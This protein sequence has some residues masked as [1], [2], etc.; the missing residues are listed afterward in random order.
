MQCDNTRMMNNRHT[1][2][3]ST[4][5]LWGQ[6]WTGRHPRATPAME[7]PSIGKTS[8]S[9]DQGCPG[10]SIEEPECPSTN[11]TEMET[12][13]Q[14]RH[15][16]T[17]PRTAH[18]R[19]RQ[20]GDLS[21]VIPAT[22]VRSLDKERCPSARA[23]LKVLPSLYLKPDERVHTWRRKKGDRGGECCQR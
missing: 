18:R 16:R 3:Q 20:H 7:G 14:H 13:S 12:G 9:R 22:E 4:Y 2:M 5:R 15:V 11:E 6:G 8:D 23:A 1:S 17:V 10:A 19:R 21:Q